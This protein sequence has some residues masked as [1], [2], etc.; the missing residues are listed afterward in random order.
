MKKYTVALSGLGSRGMIFLKSFLECSDRIEV[1][2]LCSF[3]HGRTLT[4]VWK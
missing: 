1:V 3:L 4:G 2:G